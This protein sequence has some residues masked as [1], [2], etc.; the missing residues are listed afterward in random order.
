VL[1]VEGSF[2]LLLVGELF[3]LSVIS[4]SVF[5]GEFLELLFLLVGHLLPEDAYLL[6]YLAR[7]PFGVLLFELLPFLLA[8]EDVGREGSAGTLV[9]GRASL[10][11]LLVELELTPLLVIFL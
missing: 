3:P 5:F 6:H 7:A 2:L 9:D 4:V 10:D 8:E 11:A 1:L